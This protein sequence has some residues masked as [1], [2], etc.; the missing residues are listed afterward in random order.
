MIPH[1]ILI[2]G[3]PQLD[4]VLKYTNFS[5]EIVPLKYTILSSPKRFGT[6][7]HTVRLK[8]YASLAVRLP[9]KNA[10]ENTASPSKSN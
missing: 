1:F 8:I 2:S 9:V 5:L 7:S 4:K 3:F 10:T 6:L